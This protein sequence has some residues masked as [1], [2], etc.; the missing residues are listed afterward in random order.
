MRPLLRLRLRLRERPKPMQEHLLW[1]TTK[2]SAHD[3]GAVA[4]VD[5]N[6][7][8][9]SAWYRSRTLVGGA[10]FSSVVSA[11]Q[12]L[13][14]SASM[15]ESMNL[16]PTARRIRRLAWFSRCGIGAIAPEQRR[17]ADTRLQAA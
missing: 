7:M 10:A 13:W 16:S 17:E 15:C 3:A 5:R 4:C 9:V 2:K 1:A 11:R 12:L 8:V 14:A 6:G